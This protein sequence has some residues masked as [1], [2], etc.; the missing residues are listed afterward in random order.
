MV[1]ELGSKVIDRITGFK[2]VAVARTTFINGCARM[3]YSRQ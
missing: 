3:R 1:I 2:G